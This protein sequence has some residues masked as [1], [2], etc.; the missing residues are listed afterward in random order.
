M[1]QQN[2]WKQMEA[3]WSNA[4]NEAQALNLVGGD[5][6]F[7]E[8]H[9]PGVLKLL[10]LKP[11]HKFLDLACGCLRGTINIIDYLND[12]NFYGADI[13][14]PMIHFANERV[15]KKGIQHKPHLIKI[16]SFDDLVTLN[17]KFDF[18]FA[19]S[20]VTHLYKDDIA[21]MFCAIKSI[22][23]K[24]GVFYFS[25]TR[26][27]AD[28]LEIGS[29]GAMTHNVEKLIE[30]VSSL[31]KDFKIKSVNLIEDGIIT[32]T[33]GFQNVPYYRQWMM[34]FRVIQ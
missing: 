10:G 24:N 1:T 26:H 9:Q 18:I 30:Y 32:S 20:L 19:A 15:I 16:D 5:A 31:D 25:I 23:N 29:I 28:K 11:E 34:E 12:D 27:Q 33:E 8:K 21:K 4:G 7:E 2:I 17:T 13:S 14:R 6:D 22:L 3:Y